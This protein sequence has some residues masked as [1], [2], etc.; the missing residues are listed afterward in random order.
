MGI[1]THWSVVKQVFSF[2]WQDGEYVNSHW[3]GASVRLI[4]MMVGIS[5]AGRLWIRC[6]PL[7]DSSQPLSSGLHR[8]CINECLI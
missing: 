8:D 7:A 4:G 2:D 5:L 6:L 1:W 3:N